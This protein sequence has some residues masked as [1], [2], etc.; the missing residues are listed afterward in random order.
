MNYTYIY[1]VFI[2]YLLRIYCLSNNFYELKT[3][4]GENTAVQ[5]QKCSH[6][7]PFHYILVLT[8]YF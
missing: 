8:Y 7:R 1:C 2:V 6:L 4:H 5:F 3:T